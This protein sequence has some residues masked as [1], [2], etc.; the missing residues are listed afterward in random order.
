MKTSIFTTSILALFLLSAC[1][2]SSEST[3]VASTETASTAPATASAPSMT[4][5]EADWTEQNL[6]SVQAT[7]PLTVK[8]PKS[9]K[10]EA[11][12]NGGVDIRIN[13]FYL[14]TINQPAYSSISEALESEKTSTVN[15]SLMKNGKMIVQDP[16]GYVYSAQM[17]DEPN[18]T[19]Y[20]PESH[21]VYYLQKSPDDAL[22]SIQDIRPLDNYTVAGSAYSEEVAKKVYEIIKSSAKVN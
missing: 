15:H 5:N 13:D 2:N 9:A 1:S 8:L 7:L 22:I 17:N 21:F 16:N 6:S 4:I 20:Q 18:G 3:T 12:A 11:N 14:I 10:M 19:K